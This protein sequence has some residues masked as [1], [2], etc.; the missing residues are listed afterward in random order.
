MKQQTAMQ[1]L[2]EHLDPIHSGIKNKATELLKKEVRQAVDFHRWMTFKDTE[3]YADRYF[4]YSDE[5]M[6]NEF[7]KNK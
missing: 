6:W 5:E 2:I 1:E 4:H 3:S 7:L